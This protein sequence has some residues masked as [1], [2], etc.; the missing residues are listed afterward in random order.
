MGQLVFD[1]VSGVRFSAL[2]AFIG[3]MCQPVIDQPIREVHGVKP[4]QEIVDLFE[5]PVPALAA[6]KVVLDHFHRSTS[7]RVILF[8]MLTGQMAIAFFE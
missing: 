8:Y 7:T 6:F 5:A 3:L 4:D 2:G 1:L